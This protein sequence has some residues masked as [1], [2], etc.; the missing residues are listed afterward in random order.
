MEIE[1]SPLVR[2]AKMLKEAEGMGGTG[3]VN[4]CSC[5]NEKSHLKVNCFKLNVA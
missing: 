4:F 1:V 2:S 5:P 3:G